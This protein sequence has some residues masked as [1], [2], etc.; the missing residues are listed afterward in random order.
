MAKGNCEFN[1]SGRDYLAV[2]I[3][4][5]FFLSLLTMGIY[6]PWAWV[7]LLRL[8]ASHTRI[9]GKPM[10][11]SGT[12]GQLFVLG[13]ITG[14]LTIVTLGIYWPW[15][16]CRI[17][18]WKAQNT[19]VEGRPSQFVGT[20]G[21]LFLFSLIHFFLLPA[22]TF[23][24]YAFYAMYRYYAWKQEHFRYGGAKTSFGAGFWGCLKIYLIIAVILILLPAAGA[25]IHFPGMEVLAPLICLLVSPWLIAMF[26]DWETRG[27]VVGDEE[28][29][30][31]FP[32]VRTP[33]LWVLVFILVVL[34]TMVAAALF[35][36]EELGP[37]LGN[38]GNL[39]HLLEMGG[40]DLD[41]DGSVRGR[42]KRPSPEPATPSPPKVAGA[43]A[44]TPIGS[45]KTLPLAPAWTP[46]A[47][48]GPISKEA[49]EKE[50]RE[51]SAV[52]KKDPQHADAYYSRGCLHARAGELEAAEAA[53]KTVVTK[54]DAATAMP[55]TTGDS[56][57][58][59]KT[60]LS[61]PLRT[62]PRPLR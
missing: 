39:G 17:A 38:M 48:E 35:V 4:H 57:V 26:F 22:L 30:E 46:L 3:V 19:L 41:R 56:S 25:V 47:Q 11:F 7:R 6:S 52:I 23:G 14:L 16:A 60:I 5:V 33:L 9:N 44:T 36:K 8:R 29:V 10:T 32:R 27:L 61:R 50:M 42:V 54:V 58:R 37:R 20:G 34:G 1:G 31:H 62:S 59:G 40:D 28:G 21:R 43:K 49:Y 15:A 51:L 13:L 12:G 24:L 55:F 53:A 45:G 2:F 18:A